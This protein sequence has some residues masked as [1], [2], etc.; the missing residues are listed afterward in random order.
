ME[1]NARDRTPRGESGLEE[2]PSSRA[3]AANPRTDRRPFPV[4]RPTPI[5]SLGRRT[6][7]PGK[8]TPRR[9][10]KPKEVVR[11]RRSKDPRETVN[12]IAEKN[13]G[14]EPFSEGERQEGRSPGEPWRHGG[15][16][17]TWRDFEG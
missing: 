3:V 9:E 6:E 17:R 16:L 5:T 14:A 8:T 12:P 7:K 10:K 1:T 4:K 2:D 11:T 15:R 13:P